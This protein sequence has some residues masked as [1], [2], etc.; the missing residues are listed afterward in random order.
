MNFPVH[1]KKIEKKLSRT[2][3]FV[4]SFHLNGHAIGFN[5]Y[6][7][8]FT[9]RVK[10][11]LHNS[12]PFV[13]I[14]H[15]WHRRFKWTLFNYLIY[16]KKSS[17]PRESGNVSPIKSQNIVLFTLRTFDES[18]L[19]YRQFWKMRENEEWNQNLLKWIRI[20]FSYN[21]ALLFTLDGIQDFSQSGFS[22]FW[23]MYSVRIFRS[24]IILILVSS[25][26][27]RTMSHITIFKFTVP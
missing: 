16:L 13:A 7:T 14:S 4:T 24:G 3:C 26:M 15:A 6:I 18:P 22:F 2:Q 17:C 25:P 10:Q 1:K 27:W 9:I 5:D 8:R 19:N 20:S 21:S 12:L 11:I 23:Q